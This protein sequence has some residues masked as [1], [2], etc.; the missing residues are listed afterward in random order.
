MHTLLV[1]M[2]KKKLAI[3]LLLF[4]YFWSMYVIGRGKWSV[5]FDDI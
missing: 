1:Y 4:I 2:Y 3:E 5:V